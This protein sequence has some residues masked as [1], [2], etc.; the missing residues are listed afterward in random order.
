MRNYTQRFLEKD[1]D[2]APAVNFNFSAGNAK[3]RSALAFRPGA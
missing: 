1:F 3:G 2:R